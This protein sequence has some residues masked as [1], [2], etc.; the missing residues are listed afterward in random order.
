MKPDRAALYS[1]IVFAAAFLAYLLIFD[2][3]FDSEA[4]VADW[5]DNG[6][7]SLYLGAVMVMIA[8]VAFLSLM[9][10]L[11]VTVGNAAGS[12]D[13]LLSLMFGGGVLFVGLLWVATPID[14]GI[15]EFVGSDIDFN[16]YRALSNIAHQQLLYSQIAVAVVLSVIFMIGRRSKAWPTWIVWLTGAV[17]ITSV[18]QLLLPAMILLLPIWA[19]LFAAVAKPDPEQD[20]KA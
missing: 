17:A 8:G 10:R 15:S 7:A 19:V 9:S 6:T 3:N 2:R 20:H 1:A 5:L 4:E 18:G 13:S 14:V 11:K 12:S 16:T